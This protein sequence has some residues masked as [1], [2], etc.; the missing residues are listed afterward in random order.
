MLGP[1]KVGRLGWMTSGSVRPKHQGFA[2]SADERNSGE[3]ES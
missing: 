2:T 1:A 3:D